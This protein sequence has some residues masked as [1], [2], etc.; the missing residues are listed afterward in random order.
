MKKHAPFLGLIAGLIAL[1]QISKAVVVRTVPFYGHASVIPGFFAIS[2]IH[3]KGAI[4]GTFSQSGS[5][6]VTIGLIAAQLFALAMV[7]IYFLKTPAS[8]KGMKLA[9]SLIMAGAVGNFID[10]IARGYVIDFL[11]FHVGRAYFP[12]F[13]AADSCITIGAALLVLVFFLRRP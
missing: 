3:N 11:E 12:T 9:L 8:Q 6:L 4:F 1:D 7:I 5:P 2:H 10:R 13:N